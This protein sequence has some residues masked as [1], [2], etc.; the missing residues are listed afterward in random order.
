MIL[1]NERLIFKV[2]FIGGGLICKD[3][4]TNMKVWTDA[5]QER[6]ALTSSVLSDMRA[7]KM[8]GL[9][10]VL[11]TLI[12]A[13]RVEETR[14]MGAFRTNL[15]WALLSAMTPG[16]WAPPVTFAVFSIQ[17][18]LNG[19]DAINTTQVFTSLSLISLLCDPASA[20]VQSV[21]DVF[22][23]VGCSDRIQKF[24]VSPQREDQRYTPVVGI[25]TPTAP[26]ISSNNLELEMI[27]KNG[28]GD[29][30]N[31]MA[32]SVED[33]DIRPAESA[34]V[35]LRGINFDIPRGSITIFV[36][37][38]GSG[39]TTLL[40]ALLG[41]IP[42]ET[43]TVKMSSE[44]VSFCSQTAWLPNTTIRRAICGSDEENA[45][46]NKW[47]RS[48][49]DA[50]A[51]SHDLDLLQDGDQ[52]VIGSSSAALSGGQ[53]Q[54]VALARAVYARADLVILDDVLSA[55]DAKTKKT[56]VENLLGKDGLFKKLK[57]TVLL[58]THECKYFLLRFTVANHIK[59][60]TDCYHPAKYFSYADQ[61][62]ALHDGQIKSAATY[63]ELQQ[64]GLPAVTGTTSTD[65]GD[66][67]EIEG[68][69]DRSLRT[70]KTR[71]LLPEQDS[72]IAAADDAR[73]TG[74]WS[75]YKYYFK[76][77]GLKHGSFFFVMTALSSFF[78]SFGSQ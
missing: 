1:L 25:W 48:V 51:L 38:V 45:G 59:S 31:G 35:V 22:A 66:N 15:V 50:C 28:D 71:N 13:S 53:E 60:K 44:R 61:I 36:G 9:S 39:K 64:D 17:A 56:V 24:L 30:L 29:S 46:E 43:G 58:V 78:M 23:A 5:V 74:E 37:V 12:Q 20:L 57:S 18:A 75:T 68:A 7:V 6:I 54:R 19:T 27:T 11:S 67:S 69:P 14:L 47:Y 49:L 65:D 63:Q 72:T 33:A 62:M 4:G 52:T 70:K 40:R 73:A 10:K 41:E 32:V 3:I 55:L 26:S 16:V 2:G 21:V 76:S 42:C 8:M 77:I 34:A